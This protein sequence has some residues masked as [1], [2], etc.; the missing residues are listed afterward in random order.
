M[1]RR[2]HVFGQ[3][4]L[5]IAAGE[6]DIG[7]DD[8]GRITVAHLQQQRRRHG[9]PD[10]ATRDHENSRCPQRL[11]DPAKRHTTISLGCA[12]TSR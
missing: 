9:K 8:L 3:D 6:E 7:A 4:L 11:E 12:Q 5:R 1:P 10:R 2:L